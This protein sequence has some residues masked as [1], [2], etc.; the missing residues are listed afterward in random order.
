MDAG[1]AGG[2]AWKPTVPSA[3]VRP[4]SSAEAPLRAWAPAR[5]AVPWDATG[6]GAVVD[7]RRLG[8]LVASVQT[9]EKIIVQAVITIQ[10]C[11]RGYLVRRTIRVWHQ[12]AVIIQAAWRGHCAR[13]NLAQL[14]RAATVIQ[15]TWRGYFTRRRR[16]QQMLLPGTW[17]GMGGRVHST[18]NHRCFQSCQPKACTLCQSL[19]PRLGSLPSAVMLVGSSP[20]TCHTCGQTL[21]TRVVQGMGQGST[22]QAAMPWGCDTQLTPR[23]PRRQLLGQNKAAVIIQSAWR[24]FIVRHRLRQQQVAAKMLQ[25]TWRGHYTRASL[26]T[27]ALLGPT[28]WDSPQNTQWPGV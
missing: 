21:P 24:G 16:A 12:W 15:A 6:S 8:E 28:A 19:S 3:V 22:R 25:A 17:V 9:V 18:S 10:A 7:P 20:R 26:T 1:V 2:Q 14:C 11:A 23:S 13:R 27:D 4:M 5:C